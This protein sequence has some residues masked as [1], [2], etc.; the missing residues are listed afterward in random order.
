MKITI[1]PQG[2]IIGAKK[3]VTSGTSV[4]NQEEHQHESDSKAG[5][6]SISIGND[7]MRIA[8]KL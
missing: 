8:G 7:Q 3:N 1:T 4:S 6:S 2:M 5:Q